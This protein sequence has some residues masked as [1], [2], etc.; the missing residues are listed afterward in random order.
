MGG[1]IGNEASANDVWSSPDGKIWTQ[2]TKSAN[3]SNRGYHAALVFEDLMWV[4]GGEWSYY[5][6]YNDVW[7]SSD[8]IHWLPSSISP[9]WRKRAWHSCVAFDNSL[10]IIGGY[11]AGALYV[12]IDDVY[13]S[14]PVSGSY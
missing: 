3:W 5:R 9:L 7:Y 12:Y 1:F 13:K 10:W 8:G 2:E 14:E 6:A 4:I 11:D